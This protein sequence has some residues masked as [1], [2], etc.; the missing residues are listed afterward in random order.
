MGRV[1]DDFVRLIF[2]HTH[3]ESSILDGELPQESEQFRFF[4][5]SRLVNIK[6]SVG[7]I[8]AKVSTMRVTIPID[9]STRPFILIPHFFNFRRGPPLLNPSLV[10]FP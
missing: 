3:R 4:R 10:L 9:L 5:A 6:D 2:L 7:L 1:Y 8:L